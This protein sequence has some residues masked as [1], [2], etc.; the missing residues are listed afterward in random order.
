MDLPQQMSRITG[1]L[2]ILRVKEYI[3]NT[4]VFAPLIFSGEFS[5][6]H[7]IN[8]SLFTFFLFC[9]SSSASYIVN[10]IKDIESDKTHPY[11][12]HARPL[13]AQVLS[14]KEALMLLAT[15]Y[16]LIIGSLL[17]IPQITYLILAHLGLNLLYSYQLKHKPMIDLLCISMG[18]VLRVYAGGVVIGVSVSWFIYLSAFC[19][20]LYL[21]STKRYL[22]IKIFGKTSRKVLHQYTPHGLLRFAI[23]S[24]LG[25]LFF[26][27]AFVLTE[28]PTLMI[29]IPMVIIG[30]FRFWY[31]FDTEKYHESP[32]MII[33]K[34]PIIIFTALCWATFCMYLGGLR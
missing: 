9:L 2:C 6:I 13:A 17:I 32:T 15:L 4:F 14:I 3:K 31:I 7:A 29:T 27:T 22:E 30:L 25:A 8:L 33:T 16:L 23:L 20:A 18:F 11:K 34:D 10:D 5:N 26:Y 28:K 12:S 1:V 19:L 21:I 24:A